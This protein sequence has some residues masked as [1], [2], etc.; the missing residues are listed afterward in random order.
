MV[1]IA[2]SILLADFSKL[3]EEIKSVE[4]ADYLHIDVMDGVFVPNISIGLP[5]LESVRRITGMTLDI[6][7]MITKPSR[8]I[9]QFANAGGDIIV[10]HVEAEAPEN[11]MS[12]IE[13]IHKLDKKAGLS[14]KP[15]T[16]VGALLPYIEALDMVL[17]MTVEPGFGGQ[18]F[19]A[20]MLPKISELR[21]IIDSRGIYCDIEVDGGLN[22][23]T[24]KLCIEAGANVLVAG[25]DIFCAPDRAERIAALRAARPEG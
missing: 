22:L 25:N 13:Y 17:V 19:I 18:R 8:Y 9:A 11:I 20:E 23:E 4:S 12:A 1:K 7:L 21:H 14:I 24:A 5:V 3:G 16:P 6:H 10:F 2:P 15:D